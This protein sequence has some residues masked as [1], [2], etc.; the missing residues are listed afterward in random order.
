[1]AS[2]SGAYLRASWAKDRLLTLNEEIQRFVDV[3]VEN[4]VLQGNF[5]GRGPTFEVGGHRPIPAEVLMLLSEV[6]FH[7]RASLDYVVYELSAISS[8]SYENGT[9]FPI[10]DTPAGFATRK[11]TYLKGLDP[12]HVAT[13]ETLQPYRGA[14][15][16][17]LLR[18]LSNQDEH[19]TFP[20]T[21]HRMRLTSTLP[22]GLPEKTPSGRIR[23]KAEFNGVLSIAFADGTP[24]IRTLDEL[25]TKVADTVDLFR[26]WFADVSGS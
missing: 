18:T 10:E 22:L 6:V 4:I 19:R 21:L 13:I 2:L 25:H 7:L 12:T 24:V 20:L 3:E 17:A 1:M 23:V 8:G 16:A 26:P 11:R 15:W 14:D 5:D 9:Q